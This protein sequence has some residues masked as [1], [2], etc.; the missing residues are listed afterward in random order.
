[1][2]LMLMEWDK[3]FYWSHFD[4]YP[5]YI[6]YP[7]Q[8]L[9]FN[10]NQFIGIINKNNTKTPIYTSQNA[11]SRFGDDGRPYE[12]IMDK[13]LFD[14]DTDF[15]SDYK[16]IHKNSIK[17]YEFFTANKIPS[18]INF[19]GDG[20]H[21]FPIFKP[22]RYDL[23]SKLRFINKAIAEGLKKELNLQSLN[24][25]CSEPK[26]LMR[27]MGTGHVTID[28]GFD[29][30]YDIPLNEGVMENEYDEIVE[31]SKNKNLKYG[32]RVDSNITYKE[33]TKLME[34]LKI[35][36]LDD[37]DYVFDVP[38]D[39][40]KIFIERED[41]LYKNLLTLIPSYPC[42]VNA[43]FDS[44]PPHFVRVNFAIIMKVFG[45]LPDVESAQ[46]FFDIMA[47]YWEDGKNTSRRHEQVRSIYNSRYNR[48][49]SCKRLESI[50]I[51]KKCP[52]FRDQKA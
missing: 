24:P 29:N 26:H 30:K 36:S 11:Y 41:E 18:Q 12:I 43:I 37:I 22:K 4:I 6:G 42:L 31:L 21:N 20:F 23:N 15:I 35:F 48:L 14:I 5:R 25:K 17:L 13:M 50:C 51:G 40:N 46:N 38:N 34:E 1:M 32:K 28:N 3:L 45:I 10:K 33:Y 39:G 19:S 9:I 47:K 16:I 7:Y 27:V 8:K 52:R 2:K 44:N 49:P